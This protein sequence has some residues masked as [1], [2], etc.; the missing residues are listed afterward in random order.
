MGDDVYRAE[1]ARKR[2]ERRRRAAGDLPEREEKKD[3]GTLSHPLRKQL[4]KV[5]DMLT[6]QMALP[7]RELPKLNTKIPTI[8]KLAMKL[9]DA[10]SCDDLLKL[11][12]ALKNRNL[13]AQ[14]KPPI[15]MRTVRQHF[16]RVQNLY[17]KM[18]GKPGLDC[19]SF[20]FLR[21]TSKVLKFIDNTWSNL[22]T[23]NT[24]QQSISSILS[25][26]EGYQKEYKIYSKAS[27]VLRKVIQGKDDENLVKE[28]ETFV[29]WKEIMKIL[30]KVG[31]PRDRAAI[32]LLTIMPPR[33]G[34][35][36]YLKLGRPPKKESEDYNWLWMDAK[37]P[38][39]TYDRYKTFKVYGR[40]TFV[41]PKQVV[42]LFR[43]YIKS[44][45]LKPGDLVF[46]TRDGTIHKNPSQ[47]VRKMFKKYSDLGIGIDVLRHSAITDFLAQHRSVKAKKQFARMMAHNVKTQA[48][49]F[50]LFGDDDEED[51]SDDEKVQGEGMGLNNIL[52]KFSKLNIASMPN[53]SIDDMKALRSMID[54]LIMQR[55]QSDGGQVEMKQPVGD[56]E[57]K[58]EDPP[59]T[60]TKR[61]RR[62]N[63]KPSPWI[64]FV[65]EYRAKHP[66]LSYQDALKAASA[67]YKAKKPTEV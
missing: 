17:S 37:R 27:S 11:L 34:E 50:R 30:P 48:Q 64:A 9:K 19:T 29:P 42:K 22:N 66:E 35:L 38:N 26:L 14:G 57:E 56:V 32:G 10:H 45:G 49:Y 39:I 65:K 47:F 20:E 7:S 55:E 44:A 61:K 12:F 41:L 23:R 13:G 51:D 63:A 28:N 16:K 18:T 3:P 4:Q 52:E 53:T 6:A 5:V 43:E 36:V 24:Y 40:Q 31:D 67:E 59:K 15:Q 8:P 1:Q 25:G 62:K 2:A 54:G 33:R 60:K 46:P 21:D 58:T